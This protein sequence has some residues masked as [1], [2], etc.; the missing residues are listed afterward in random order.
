MRMP[1]ASGLGGGCGYSLCKRQQQLSSL[2]NT[3]SA[4]IPQVIFRFLT[5]RQSPAGGKN[6]LL[7]VSDQLLLGLKNQPDW[8]E[9]AAALLLGSFNSEGPAWDVLRSATI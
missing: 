5:A 6:L 9:V 2:Q 4:A 8:V 7:E 3:E 1:S